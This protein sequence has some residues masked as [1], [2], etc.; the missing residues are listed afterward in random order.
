[1]ILEQMVKV[2]LAIAFTSMIT[3]LILLS[4]DGDVP[5]VLW[6]IFGISAFLTLTTT[7]YF[8]IRKQFQRKK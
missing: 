4:F 2:E 3:I 8:V 7:L 6:W 5:A 1:M